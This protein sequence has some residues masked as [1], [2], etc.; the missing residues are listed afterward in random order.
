[1]WQNL[2]SEMDAFKQSCYSEWYRRF[3]NSL[4]T[5][6]DEE[7]RTKWQF[8]E[9][10]NSFLY[11]ISFVISRNE[12]GSWGK[13]T[14]YP[15][16][17]TSHML[18][19]LTDM[20]VSLKDH[21]NSISPSLG[22][23]SPTGNLYHSIGVLI[24]HFKDTAT[25][26]DDRFALW[27]TDFWDDCHIA[28]SLLKVKDELTSIDRRKANDLDVKWQRSLSWLQEQV[29]DRFRKVDELSSWY[30]PGFHAAAIQL[31]DYLQ[32]TRG[33]QN[34]TALIASV[35]KD[36]APIIKQRASR[37]NS[38]WEKRFA[39]HA[40]QLIVAW[41]EKRTTY[42]PLRALDNDMLTLYEEL[43][44]RQDEDGA[45][46]YGSD[47]PETNYNTAR[48]LAACYVMEKENGVADS[49]HIR[50]AHHYLLGQTRQAQ[51]FDGDLKS[52][53]NS[54][55]AYQ[56]LF[57][58][59][60]PNIHFHLLVSL[61]YRLHCLGLEK[62]IFSPPEV[63]DHKLLEII[64]RVAREKLEDDSCQ[65]LEPM[66][67][68][69][70]LFE[71]VI[72]RTQLLDEFNE[73][74]HTKTEKKLRRFLSST[75]TEVRSI[76]AKS[77][78]KDLW[79]REGLLNFL[80]LIDHLSDLE[81]ERAFYA[82][83][84][85]HLN[86]EVL[87]FLLG[88]YIYYEHE[89]LRKNINA[90][91]ESTYK[92]FNANPPKDIEKEFLFRWKMIATFH[93]IGYLFEID[94]DEKGYA[95]KKDLLEEK[96]WLMEESFGMVD[97]VRREF[98][99][100]YFKQ[101]TGGSDKTSLAG[102]VSAIEAELKP[103]LP[104]IR[105]AENLFTL[106]TTEAGVDAF[107]MID[108]MLNTRGGQRIKPGLIKDYF[109]L[110]R[111]TRSKWRDKFYDHGVMSALILLKVADIHRFYLRQLS[112]AR[113]SKKL[114]RYPS[115]RERLQN[116]ATDKEAQERFHIRFSH[117]AG[118]IALHNIYP[119]LYTKKDCSAF[120]ARKKRKE[121]RLLVSSFHGNSNSKDRYAISPDQNPM[122]YLTAL[123]DVIQDW[124][125]HSFRKTPYVQDEKTPIAAAEVMIKCEENKIVVTPL[126]ASARA[127]Y[128]N[129][130]KGIKDYLLK[131]NSYVRL[132]GLD[133]F[134]ED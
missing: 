23:S 81:N 18:R 114:Q 115:F 15:Q 112:D 107:V 105:K 104:G 98:I 21:W 13:D 108:E 58:F 42:A 100:E 110:C 91:I 66:G 61:S 27:G 86:H 35:V 36:V 9:V 49:Y 118:A 102:D 14:P 78:I 1:M 119:K 103:Y 33:L 127:R 80:P 6:T 41:K 77:L 111:T 68:N 45:W 46:H 72:T 89:A 71:D 117:V 32:Q 60:I 84:R 29:K 101:F 39:W 125:R 106:K 87:L 57:G 28:L 76:Q 22:T 7:Q 65:A 53:V 128:S 8:L 123:A 55:E 19:T 120:D 75:M 51:P 82:F 30:G 43:K 64:R 63:D 96:K 95:T 88:A 129:H 124:D 130:L 12:G 79:T 52:C 34:S 73:K 3:R 50:M 121:D 37:P 90:E 44:S 54:I 134:L 56:K 4:P 24:G 116:E 85:D 83:Y 113:F 2:E 70:R 69:A 94:P 62:T 59:T 40:G 16:L 93:D 126:S 97:A 131:T 122:A 11:L 99:P 47:V 74:D 17:L 38:K 67:V 109:K 26:R 31:F 5:E 25:E 48:A 132:A 92:H 10:E 20:K 133:K